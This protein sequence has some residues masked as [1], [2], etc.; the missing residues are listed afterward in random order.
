MTSAR[1]KMKA[2]LSPQRYE[3][4]LRKDARAGK[5]LAKEIS[6]PRGGGVT[7]CVT[8][9]TELLLRLQNGWLVYQ[10]FAAQ[11]FLGVHNRDSSG[12]ALKITT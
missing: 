11:R 6:K 3:A 10:H 8:R 1:L 5:Q 4:W 2:A 9:I 7:Q 12:Q